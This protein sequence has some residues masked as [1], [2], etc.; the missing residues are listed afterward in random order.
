MYKL[1]ASESL[2]TLFLSFWVLKIRT[3]LYLLLNS[4]NNIKITLIIDNLIKRY[5][6]ALLNHQETNRS[7]ILVQVLSTSKINLI[8]TNSI[9][10]KVKRALIYNLLN[11]FQTQAFLPRTVNCRGL[12][13]IL[14]RIGHN[15]MGIL[16][17]S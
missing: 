6:I 4:I 5:L 3:I 7:T 15:Y 8:P 13:K 14:N 17:K 1:R 11:S 10:T 9:R 2:D 16:H 12:M